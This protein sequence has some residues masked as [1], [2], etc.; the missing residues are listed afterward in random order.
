M[1]VLHFTVHY[2]KIVRQLSYLLSAMGFDLFI[3]FFSN[4][5]IIGDVSR[6]K[7]DLTRSKTS[8]YGVPSYLS[9]LEATMFQSTL[10][11]FPIIIITLLLCWE[12]I[13]VTYVLLARIGNPRTVVMHTIVVVTGLGVT[14]TRPMRLLFFDTIDYYYIELNYNRLIE[15]E[16]II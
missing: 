9:A 1:P 13:P 4:I 15:I 16:L 6:F 12:Y 7:H 14:G 3:S 8:A 10:Q 5:W 2:H 11:C